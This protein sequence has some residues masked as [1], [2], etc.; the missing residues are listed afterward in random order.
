VPLIMVTGAAG[1]IGSVVTQA[2]LKEG[3][4]V[5]SVDNLSRGH[6]AVISKETKFFRISVGDG[7]AMDKLFAQFKVDAVVHLAGLTQVGESVANPDLY[8]ANNL[9]DGLTLLES[10][11]RCGVSKMIFSSS[12]A[13]YGVPNQTPI[14][15]DHPIAPVNPYGDTKARMEEALAWYGEAYGFQSVSL[16][17]FNAAG[18]SGPVGEDHRPETHLIPNAINVALGKMDHLSLY[19]DDYPT[20]DGTAVRDYVHVEDIAQAHVRALGAIGELPRRA[21][22]VGTGKGYSVREVIDVA[23][24][25]CLAD[26][27]VQVESKR[28]GDPPELVADA[29]ALM[30]DLGWTPQYSTIERMIQD[31]FRWHRDH[32]NGYPGG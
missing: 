29:S 8:Y 12:A 21:Y 9:R 17:Y 27:P 1:F 16:R 5:L 13:V 25:V 7:L 30:A 26:I 32:E 24:R 20:P 3:N 19:G 14:R 22:N 18:A 4:E 2:L 15:E 31:A 23:A 6:R 28:A 10:M 11:H